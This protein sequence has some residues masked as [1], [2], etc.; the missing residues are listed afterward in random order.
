MRDRQRKRIAAVAVVVRIGSSVVDVSLHQGQQFVSIAEQTFL[1]VTETPQNAHVIG[2]FGVECGQP[3]FAQNSVEAANDAFG[4]AGNVF[5][6]APMIVDGETD[7]GA[8]AFVVA[9]DV[10]AGQADREAE[11]ADSGSNVEWS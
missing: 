1:L 10:D 2:T 8:G 7:K 5:G 3:E 6:C 11:G 9:V 4:G